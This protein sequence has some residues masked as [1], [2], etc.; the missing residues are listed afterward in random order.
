MERSIEERKI[1]PEEQVKT[2]ADMM[3]VKSKTERAD[4]IHM[5]KCYFGHEAHEEVASVARIAQ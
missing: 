1:S 2:F 3:T 5:I 4:V